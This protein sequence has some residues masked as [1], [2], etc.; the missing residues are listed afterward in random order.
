MDSQTA[1]YHSENDANASAVV[2]HNVSAPIL[3]TIGV[4]KVYHVGK[5]M[6]SP[7]TDITIQ[8]GYGDFA[9]IFGPSGAGKSTLMN[10]LMGLENPDVG[11]VFIKGSSLYGYSEED[12]TTLRRKK[13]SYLPQ[14]QYWL[15]YMDVV[16]NVALP[17]I[18]NG[19][20]QRKAR[21]RSVELLK[22]VG[23]ENVLSHSPA[24][25]STGQQQK[26]ALMRAIIKEPWFI[27]ADEPTAHLDSKSVEEVTKILLD[28]SKQ[29]GITTIMV[30]HDLSFLKLS[31]RWF[32]MK[33]GRIWD[34]K[35]RQNPFNNIREAIDYVEGNEAD[36]AYKKV[37]L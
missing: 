22:E 21:K 24:E 18:L 29:Y 10:M 14:S 37:G 35:D 2:Q 28:Y 8:V 15:E 20:S 7:A 17:L 33:D 9:V 16:D 23:L 19:R 25:L 31:K 3:E 32:F 5:D 11:E 1:V 13:I 26:A 27:F 6:V 4:S 30:T 12:R 34:I 36:K